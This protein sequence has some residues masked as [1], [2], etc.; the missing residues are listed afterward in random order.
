MW[1][2]LLP[3][4]LGE[5]SDAL[6]ARFP[7]EPVA[8]AAIVRDLDTVQL[9]ESRPPTP[10]DAAKAVRARS[11][12]GAGAG[13]RL[14]TP[15]ATWDDLVLAPD[16]M[17]QLHEAVRAWSLQP[18][19][20][21][22]LGLPAAAAPAP[23]ACGCCSAGRPAPAR[24]S[25]PRCSPRELG[26]DLLRR[27][28]RRASSRSGS[29]RPRRTWPRSSTR[30]S[31]RRRCSSSTRPTRCSASAPRSPTR[32]TATPT[33]RRPT[34]CS[35]SSAST[36]S[37]SSPPTCARTSTRAFTRRLD[38]IVE[39]DPPRRRR[40]R[41]LWR[42]HLPPAAPLAGRRLA[43]LAARYRL[44]GGSSATPPR[45]RL[46]RRRRAGGPETRS[47]TSHAL[48]REYEK[49]GR[50]FPGAPIWRVPLN[51]GDPE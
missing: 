6:S 40:A 8:A 37:P 13:V 14:I 38:F 44:S 47:A 11:G 20:A 24:R 32:T 18:H 5:V 29:A 41:A 4:S 10:D 39:F 21:R 22:R 12:L 2:A 9:I 1:R 33:S 17:A 49:A 27:R 3:A 42:R 25:P 35:A 15:T 46:P 50:A 23:A 43:R 7:L 30:P 16:R 34:C 45:R 51:R 28:P 48:R 31:A 19:G 26:V 36:G